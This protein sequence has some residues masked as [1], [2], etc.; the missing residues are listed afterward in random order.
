MRH[1][2]LNL[3]TGRYM[4]NR[5]TQHQHRPWRISLLRECIY[6]EFPHFLSLHLL[7][8]RNTKSQRCNCFLSPFSR[9][10]LVSLLQLLEVFSDLSLPDRYRRADGRPSRCS[11]RQCGN[12]RCSCQVRGLHRTP[13]NHRC[14]LLLHVCTSKTNGLRSRW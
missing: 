4:K 7:F 9:Y 11:P 3:C 12:I 2:R 5:C 10:G 6:S 1:T 13:V 8:I 14:A